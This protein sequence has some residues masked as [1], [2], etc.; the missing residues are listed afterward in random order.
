MG[1]GC[2]E[3]CVLQYGIRYAYKYETIFYNPNDKQI[4][5]KVITTQ[6][7]RT[8]VEIYMASN[9]CKYFEEHGVPKTIVVDNF[10]DESLLNKVLGNYVKNNEVSIIFSR[11]ELEVKN[12]LEE[13]SSFID[14]VYSLA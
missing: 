7:Y 13:D 3:H 9:I 6:P 12:L 1:S 5:D 14:D 10:F 8:Y 4:V 11:E 2:I